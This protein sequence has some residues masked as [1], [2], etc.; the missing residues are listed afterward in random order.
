[1]S[2]RPI[3]LLL[4][5]LQAVRQVGPGRWFARCPA[6]D[7]RGPSLSIREAS[8]STALL[9]DFGGRCTAREIV[10]KIGLDLKSLFP[11]SQG[12][13]HTPRRPP[14]E[15]KPAPVV[16]YSAP[17]HDSDPL[18]KTFIARAIEERAW[19][20]DVEPRFVNECARSNQLVALSIIEDAARALREY[21]RRGSV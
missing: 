14:P 4:P 6:H 7:D 18:W 10:E 11:A 13:V 17:P 19:S 1:M 15:P 20:C 8:D 2:A 21:A 3:E 16:W 9:N 12:R 5:R